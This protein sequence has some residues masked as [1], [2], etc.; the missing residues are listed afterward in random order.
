VGLVADAAEEVWWMS[1]YPNW[2][3][4]GGCCM[5]GVVGAEGG[6][7]TRAGGVDG[8][9]EGTEAVA[10]AGAGAGWVSGTDSSLGSSM[11]TASSVGLLT[12]RVGMGWAGGGAGTSSGTDS[13]GV[14][15]R[16]D[17]V[18]SAEMTSPESGGWP[19]RESRCGV[20]R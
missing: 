5:G 9:D 8:L 13:A 3:D 15:P 14:G 19:F 1:K 6:V 17:S 18:P 12:M 4:A 11:K 20:R 10:S 16:T 7:E 2:D